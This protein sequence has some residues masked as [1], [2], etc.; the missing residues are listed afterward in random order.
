MTAVVLLGLLVGIGVVGVVHGLRTPTP[1]L[2]TVLT[3]WQ[4]TGGSAHP[5]GRAAPDEGRAGLWTLGRRPARVVVESR[6]SDHRWIRHLGQDLAVTGRS[7]DLVAG[8]VVVAAGAGILGP[9]LLWLLLVVA[10]QS[11]AV[12]IVLGA[13]LLL[14]LAGAALILG[15]LHQAAEEERRHVRAVV[16]SFVDLVVMGL[17]GG[18]GIDGAVLA[19]AQVSPARAARRMTAVLVTARESGSPSWDALS[20]LGT[21]IGVVELVDLAGV[22]RLAGTEGTRIRQA[23]ESRSA[24]MRRHAQAD[25]ESAANT[26]TERLF[27]PGALLLVGFL[28]FLGFPAFQRILGGFA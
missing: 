8:Q 10:G 17:A 15:A 18:V 26:V 21:A 24:A 23:L 11:M 19:A 2:A 22:V 4:R 12:G 3:A 9:P 16:A 28:V 1:T 5:D 27:L 6:W 20:S 7:R 13:M 14:P 25:A